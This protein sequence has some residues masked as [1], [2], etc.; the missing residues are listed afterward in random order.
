MKKRTNRFHRNIRCLLTHPHPHIHTLKIVDDWGTWSVGCTS[1]DF[2]YREKKNNQS[3][4]S[5]WET[6]VQI[7]SVST[8]S[9]A[10]SACGLLFSAWFRGT[11][12]RWI[13][14]RRRTATR[15]CYLLW[16][17]RLDENNKFDEVFRRSFPIPP[18]ECSV[19]HRLGQSS[20][21]KEVCSALRH[22]E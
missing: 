8:G 6:S 15:F 7:L 19:A 16:Q 17:E 14:L 4:K 12:S 5:I 22:C 3:K 20:L 1:L 11:L 10:V 13:R 18:V 21:R 2:I 9:L